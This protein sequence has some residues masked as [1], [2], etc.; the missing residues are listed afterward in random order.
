MKTSCSIQVGVSVALVAVVLFLVIGSFMWV[1][2]LHNSKDCPCSED[3]RRS[4]LRKFLA[5]YIVVLTLNTIYTVYHML[6]TDCSVMV[7]PVL[8]QAVMSITG[9]LTFVYVIVAIQYIKKIKNEKCECARKGRGD[10]MMIAHISLMIAIFG[11][12]VLVLLGV[13]IALPVML[14]RRLKK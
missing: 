8:W 5:F 4:F 1:N 11:L 9:I 2:K 13:I 14:R 3:W 12:A 6:S 7:R 10:E